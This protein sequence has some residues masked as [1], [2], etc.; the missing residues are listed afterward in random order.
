MT[1]RV[2]KQT[3]ETFNCHNL[4]VQYRYATS[5]QFSETQ[6]PAIA[7]ETSIKPNELLKNLINLN[8]PSL[9]SLKK[10]RN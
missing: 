2:R 9:K 3:K 5:D 7:E 4:G 1:Y 8:P 10:L 6:T